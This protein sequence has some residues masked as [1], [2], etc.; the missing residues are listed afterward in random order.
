MKYCNA[1]V[2]LSILCWSLSGCV[3]L[4]E[5]EVRYVDRVETIYPM[6]PEALQAPVKAPVVAREPRTVEAALRQGSQLRVAY[7]QL[8]TQYRELLRHATGGDLVIRV[9]AREICPES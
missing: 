3:S 6:I 5:A 2:S 9:A 8:R 1:Y 4:G 7:C